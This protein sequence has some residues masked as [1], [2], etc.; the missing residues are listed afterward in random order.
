M[1]HNASA[2]ADSLGEPGKKETEERKIIPKMMMK[3]TAASKPEGTSVSL[4]GGTFF[5]S[6]RT[7]NSNNTLI[8]ALHKL[9]CLVQPVWSGVCLESMSAF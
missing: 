5:F 9:I 4:C 6:R 1:F 8:C 7:C 2:P 3:K